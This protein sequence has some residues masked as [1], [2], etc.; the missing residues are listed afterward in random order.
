[1]P[2]RFARNGLPYGKAMSYLEVLSTVSER[3]KLW[4]RE[5]RLLSP[6]ETRW[7]PPLRWVY[8]KAK[9]AY[10]LPRGIWGQLWKVQMG[11]LKPDGPVMF[12]IKKEA[13]PTQ[14][15]PVPW[16]SQMGIYRVERRESP[17]PGGQAYLPLDPDPSLCIHTTEGSSVDGAWMT[18]NSKSAAPHFIIGEGRIV[19]CRPLD[20][21]AATIHDHNDRFIQI[22]C[23]GH[24]Q[25][26]VHRL[27]P[28]TWE[29]LIAAVRYLKQVH[30]IP[31]ARPPSWPDQLGPGIWAA[32]NPRRQTELALT[33]RG[34]FGHVDVPD[35]DPTWHWDPGSLDYT[36]LFRRVG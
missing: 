1:M 24:A 36:E 2:Y 31:M 20:K 30:G 28:Q 26:E 32:N 13:P 9:L 35:Q 17:R 21:Q 12:L 5:Y 22:E 3:A 19:Q 16:V 29:P 14:E 6:G 27:T 8:L 15:K 7:S 4:G 25:R 10:Q 18:L 33:M 23:V 11:S 34:V